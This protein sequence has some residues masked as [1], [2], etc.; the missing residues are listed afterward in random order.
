MGRLC[1]KNPKIIAKGR[2]VVDIA[3]FAGEELPRRAVLPDRLVPVLPGIFGKDV[4]EAE[5][6]R[7]ANVGEP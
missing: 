1:R 6:M 3:V 2:P 7:L 4:V 5:T